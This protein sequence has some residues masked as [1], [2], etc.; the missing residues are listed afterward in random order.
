MMLDP[1]RQELLAR[2]YKA[3]LE[4]LGVG[5]REL[6]DYKVE[7]ESAAYWLAAHYHGGQWSSLYSALSCSPYSPGMSERDLPRGDDESM[8]EDDLYRIGAE[9]IEGKD[10]E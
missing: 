7:A 3:L 5:L 10:S 4:D 1:T 2:L 8:V 6:R 9:W